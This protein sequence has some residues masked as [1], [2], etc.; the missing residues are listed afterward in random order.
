MNKT[1]GSNYFLTY[2]ILL[3]LFAAVMISILSAEDPDV[4][5]LDSQ[6]FKEAVEDRAFVTDPARE[7]DQLTIRD[8]DQ[9]VTGLLERDGRQPQGFEYSYPEH[10][11]IAAVLNEAN[12]PFKTDTQ[13]VGFWLSLFGR[14]GPIFLIV[15]F[16]LFM[17]RRMQ[18]GGQGSEIMKLG[19]SRARRMTKDQP[20]VTFADVAG[21]EEAVQELTEIKEFLEAPQKFQKLGARIP[22]GA[23]LVGPP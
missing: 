11:D 3:V 10:Y 18:G 4:E 22:K 21:A 12:I 1:P 13:K 6:E 14:L 5:K 8:E 7:E 23:L 9:T 17:M 19:K 2:A 20:K 15:L 16:F